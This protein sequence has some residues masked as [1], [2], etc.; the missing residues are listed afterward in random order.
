LLGARK[1][2]VVITPQQ[3]RRRA[4]P[5]EF[6]RIVVSQQ[7]VDHHGPEA[8]R[9]LQALLDDAVE[10]FGGHRPIHRTRLELARE[11]FWNG[12]GQFAQRGLEIVRAGDLRRASLD[13]SGKESST[14]YPWRSG[15]GSRVPTKRESRAT[16]SPGQVLPSA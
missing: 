4:N 12:I 10:E 8:R 11:R 14:P 1:Q 3:H 16:R 7:A 9:N 15:T 6:V 2:R 5:A 13:M